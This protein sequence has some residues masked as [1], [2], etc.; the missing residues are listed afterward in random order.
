MARGFEAVAGRP[1]WTESTAAQAADSGYFVASRLSTLCGCGSRT[2]SSRGPQLLSSPLLSSP[3]H[4]RRGST[5]PSQPQC[6]GVVAVPSLAC[7]SSSATMAK[8]KKA[9]RKFKAQH[10]DRTIAK[11]KASHNKKAK[12]HS[13]RNLS[14]PLILSALPISAPT[15]HAPVLTLL[16]LPSLFF[17]AMQFPL[18]GQPPPQ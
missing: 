5:R 16:P 17:P 18:L 9:T 1:W 2:R 6:R 12:A 13:Q 7:C 10:L 15:A 4:H 11:R 3:H 8:A 14:T